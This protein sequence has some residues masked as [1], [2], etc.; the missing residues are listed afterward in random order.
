MVFPE[1]FE[2]RMREMLKGEYD[3]F[4]RAM[5]TSPLFSGIRIN[6]LKD[7]ARETV[8]RE[9]GNMESVPW[10]ADGYYADKAVISGSDPYHIAGLFYFAP[11][12]AFRKHLCIFLSEFISGTGRS[13]K[14]FCNIKL[15]KFTIFYW[16][17]EICY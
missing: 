10:C 3:D 16:R 12:S 9:F 8:L 11:V 13:I 15:P 17:I 4:E 6:T 1:K 5:N 7:G 2:T 14:P